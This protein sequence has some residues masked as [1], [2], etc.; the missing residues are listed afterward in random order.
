[1][2]QLVL[3][4]AFFLITAATSG[5]TQVQKVAIDRTEA[6]TSCSFFVAAASSGNEDLYPNDFK[7]WRYECAN[8]PDP[9]RCQDTVDTLKRLRPEYLGQSGFRCGEPAQANEQTLRRR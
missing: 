1:M 3:S 9:R 4:L 8:H 5:Q 7:R 6:E 2:R